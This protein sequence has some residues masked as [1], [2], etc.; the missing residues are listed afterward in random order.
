[1][2]RIL[3]IL[4]RV[5][6][7]LSLIIGS[8][9]AAQAEVR[10]TDILGREVV[11]PAPAKRIVLGEGRHLAVLGLLHSNP[12]ESV[13]GWR[14]DK[15]LDA[16]T[17]AAY[18]ARFPEIDAIRPVGSGNR[19]LSVEAVIALE[20][21]LVVLSLMDAKDPVME[22]S[23]AQLEAAGIPV[24]YVDFFAAPQKNSLP[25]LKIFGDLTG[26]SERAAEFSA[27]YNERLTR[28]R[29]RLADPAIVRPDV[30]F[31][32]HAVPQGCCSTVGQGVFH[33]FIAT[34]GGHN[35][36]EAA[37]GGV[38]GQVSLEFLIGADPTFYV[39]T[40]G[41]HMAARGGLVLGSGV[42]QAAA[43]ASFKAL[44][45]A[46]GFNALSAVEEGRVAGVWHLFNDSPVHIVLI[47]YL[48]KL[49]HP[50]LFADVDPNATL[51]EINT[52]FAAVSV[53]GTWWV[54]P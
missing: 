7:A 43:E 35:I 15:A 12:V 46:P 3:P 17:E 18:R 39:A 51:D 22:Q 2:L 13:V 31:H 33:D 42:E 48:A 27:F 52:R 40:G 47:E 23:R 11:L 36:G 32:V 1:M 29:D 25:S 20:P 49:F 9:A 34:A 54:A 45:D 37:V 38:L 14:L 19:D 41:A 26:A 16:P 44:T 5:F 24:A 8:F 10:T 4:T 21:D 30:F 53:P 6:V 50:E 28:I